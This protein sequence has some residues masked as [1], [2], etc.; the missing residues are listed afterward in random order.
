ML[1]ALQGVGFRARIGWAMLGSRLWSNEV[2]R[3]A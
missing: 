1:L 3:W 2:C